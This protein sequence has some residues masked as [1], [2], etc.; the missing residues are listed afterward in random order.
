MLRL[1]DAS[2]VPITL[3]LVASM[4]CGLGDLHNV[5]SSHEA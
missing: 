3:T 2:L 5:H 4:S 1:D